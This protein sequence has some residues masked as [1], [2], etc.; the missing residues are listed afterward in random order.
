MEDHASSRIFFKRKIPGG[1]KVFISFQEM[2]FKGCFISERHRGDVEE[3]N[4]LVHRER[5][6]DLGLNYKC[7]CWNGMILVE[8]WNENLVHMSS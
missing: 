6:F 3:K 7:D 1:G 4:G 8:E 2:P 5:R